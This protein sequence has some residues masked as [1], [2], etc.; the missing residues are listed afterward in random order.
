MSIVHGL[1]L[2]KS[3]E[4]LFPIDLLSSKSVAVS[5][6]THRSSPSVIINFD[7]KPESVSNVVLP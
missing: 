4:E 3:A 2:H 1:V 7:D 6:E 5:L